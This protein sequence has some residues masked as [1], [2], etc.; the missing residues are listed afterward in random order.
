MFS[1]AKWILSIIYIIEDN[2]YHNLNSQ[3]IRWKEIYPSITQ[4]SQLPPVGLASAFPLT[5]CLISASKCLTVWSLRMSSLKT[6]QLT[7]P[8]SAI[9]STPFLSLVYRSKRCRCKGRQKELEK[10]FKNAM[11]MGHWMIGVTLPKGNTPL[12]SLA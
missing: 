10:A 9:I 8:K 7:R 6:T 3:N 11:G 2:I 4:L 1:W 5:F 12:S